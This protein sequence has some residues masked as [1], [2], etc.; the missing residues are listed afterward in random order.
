MTTNYL[1]DRDNQLPIPMME[2]IQQRFPKHNILPI[3]VSS[4]QRFYASI[5][6]DASFEL[7]YGEQPWVALPFDDK[8]HGEALSNKYDVAGIPTL[9]ILDGVTGE[10]KDKDG[11]TTISQARGDI[12]KVLIK[13]K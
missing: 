6:D 8:D 7:Y 11:R 1:L 4:M 2:R 5:N 3:V 13:W 9:I 12:N 10:V